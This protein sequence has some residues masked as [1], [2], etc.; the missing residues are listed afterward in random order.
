MSTLEIIQ[1]AQMIVQ[2]LQVIHNALADNEDFQA[3]KAKIKSDIG[4][5]NDQAWSV[6]EKVYTEMKDGVNVLPSTIMAAL[7]KADFL[8]LFH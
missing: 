7:E 5:F 4:D 1:A 6:I 8:N 2:I 3:V